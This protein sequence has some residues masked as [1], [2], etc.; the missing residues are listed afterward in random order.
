[1]LTSLD[2][3]TGFVFQN[4]IQ[5]YIQNLNKHLPRGKFSVVLFITILKERETKII[6]K[7]WMVATNS[8]TIE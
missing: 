8:H 5:G 3:Q 4:L 1:M 2:P 7:I 6:P